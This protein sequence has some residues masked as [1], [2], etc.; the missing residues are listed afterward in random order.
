MRLMFEWL[1]G[2]RRVRL[3]SNRTKHRL[4]TDL[5]YQLW[6]LI[7]QKRWGHRVTFRSVFCVL[8]WFCCD[9]WVY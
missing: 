8:K 5:I 7:C 2:P 1:Q 9:D 6:L 3:R 4:V